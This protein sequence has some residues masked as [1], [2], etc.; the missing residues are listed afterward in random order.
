MKLQIYIMVKKVDYVG[1]DSERSTLEK[2]FFVGK[3]AL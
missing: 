3:N 2:C 1:I